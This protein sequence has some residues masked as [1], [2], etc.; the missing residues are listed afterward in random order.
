MLEGFDLVHL[1]NSGIHQ[2]NWGKW[3]G[4]PSCLTPARGG[5]KKGSLAEFRNSSSEPVCRALW[6]GG[7]DGDFTF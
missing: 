4:N 3:F 5:P 2:L 1:L 6:A 7:A